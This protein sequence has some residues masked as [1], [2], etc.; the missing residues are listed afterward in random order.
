MIA[1]RVLAFILG[2][3]LLA[4]ALLVVAALVVVG[5]ALGCVGRLADALRWPLTVPGGIHA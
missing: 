1:R 3:G 2:L 5:V 4:V